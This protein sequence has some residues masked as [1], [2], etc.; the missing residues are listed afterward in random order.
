MPCPLYKD[1]TRECVE[2]YDEM[3]KNS[4]FEICESDK[5]PSCPVWIT[6]QGKTDNC[7]NIEFCGKHQRYGNVNL[8][9]L[10]NLAQIYCFT[11]NRVNCAIYK[12]LEDGKDVPVDLLADGSRGKIKI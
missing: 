11:E 5:Y 7:K 9:V 8:E 3:L 4:S 1:F 12:L 6:I 2:K 10:G